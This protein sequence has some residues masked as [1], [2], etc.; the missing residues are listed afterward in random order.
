[1]PCTSKRFSHRGAQYE[2]VFEPFTVKGRQRVVWALY[3]VTSEG[4]ETLATGSHTDERGCYSIDRQTPGVPDDELLQAMMDQYRDA[5]P[6]PL[7]DYSC[8]CKV[9]NSNRVVKQCDVCAGVER[10]NAD[11]A[12]GVRRRERL[13][14]PAEDELLAK[15]Q[16][17]RRYRE[18]KAAA[19]YSRPAEA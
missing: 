19:E 12:D 13:F 1:M 6:A 3:L 14:D 7:L 8:R 5:K 9:V 17:S 16:E 2:A 15:R 18:R 11:V 10:N 4:R